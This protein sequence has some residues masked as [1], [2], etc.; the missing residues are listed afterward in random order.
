MKARVT[1]KDCERVKLQLDPLPTCD[2]ILTERD[3]EQRAKTKGYTK[4]VKLPDC[5]WHYTDCKYVVV[6]LKGGNFRRAIEQLE[7]FALFFPE[8]HA[9]VT[10]YIIVL[11]STKHLSGV[12]CIHG[13]IEEGCLAAIKVGRK[14]K[15]LTIHGKPLFIRKIS[16]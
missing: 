1:R 6:E 10:R 12:K 2:Q 11:K 9:N 16:R 8:I 15:P 3:L 4:N 5:A 7:R 13:K 14:L